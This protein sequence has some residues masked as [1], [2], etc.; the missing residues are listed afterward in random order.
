MSS[1]HRLIETTPKEITIIQR[2]IH[3]SCCGYSPFLPRISFS[4][5]AI[6]Q[7][8]TTSRATSSQEPSRTPCS[9]TNPTKRHSQN[10]TPTLSPPPRHPQ[11]LVDKTQTFVDQSDDGQI[12]S[13]VKQ[14]DDCFDDC[15]DG[16]FD[17]CSRTLFRILSQT[18]TRVDLYSLGV[19]GASQKK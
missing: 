9:F 12:M 3:V 7:S 2:T 15:F 5:T 16:C 14:G 8:E 19:H 13:R 17:D 1:G 4:L 10:I 6:T 18:Q 11:T